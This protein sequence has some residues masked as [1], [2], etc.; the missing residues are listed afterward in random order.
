MNDGQTSLVAPGGAQ[1]FA[2]VV[3]T[4]VSAN[5]STSTSQVTVG[6]PYT[7]LTSTVQNTVQVTG[8]VNIVT[9]TITQHS[10]STRTVMELETPQAF[11][12][13]SLTLSS[14]STISNSTISGNSTAAI[15]RK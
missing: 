9:T 15:V 14:N 13:T 10:T 7:T 2:T 1:F 3:Y 11:N 5:L 12:A 6:D 8:V 4:T